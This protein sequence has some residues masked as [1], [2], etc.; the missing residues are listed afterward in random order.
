VLSLSMKGAVVQ[1]CRSSTS[2]GSRTRA[3]PRC[4]SRCGSG[5]SAPSAT[6]ASASTS[7]AA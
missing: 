1:L 5:C 6:R 4:T 2:A 7:C 3:A